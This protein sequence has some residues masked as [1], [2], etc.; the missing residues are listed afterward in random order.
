MCFGL[1]LTGP[2]KFGFKFNIIEYLGIKK[3]LCVQQ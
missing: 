2:N 1:L 3:V